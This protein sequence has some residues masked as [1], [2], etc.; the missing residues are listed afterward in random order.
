MKTPLP[1]PEVDFARDIV[2]EAGEIALRYFRK[3]MDVV[4]KLEAC[5]TIP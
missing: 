4:N 3:P 1:H 2:L 5:I